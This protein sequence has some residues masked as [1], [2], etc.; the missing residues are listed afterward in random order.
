MRQSGHTKWFDTLHTSVSLLLVIYSFTERKEG[1]VGKR[2]KSTKVTTTICFD[3]VWIFV[4]FVCLF[5]LFPLGI[6]VCCC[7]DSFIVSLVKLFVSHTF[8]V[9]F[10]LYVNELTAYKEQTC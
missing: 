1:S 8:V 7:Y 3:Y 9:V 5:C 2:E 4:V 6:F 10:Q